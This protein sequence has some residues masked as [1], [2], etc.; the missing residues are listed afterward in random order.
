MLVDIRSAGARKATEE[1]AANYT[2]YRGM[3]FASAAAE[4]VP[5][6]PVRGTQKAGQPALR[7]GWWPGWPAVPLVAT[8]TWDS[9]TGS[10]ASL[11]G[12][13]PGWP[14]VP[15]VATG[16]WDSGTGSAA[17]LAGWWPGWPLVPLVATGTWDSGTGSEADWWSA[18]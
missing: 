4:A 5:L 8:G 6:S 12:W 18:P 15:L 16:T 17:S 7:A 13:W 2:A 3:T 9:G 1:A 14:L 11:A 10:A